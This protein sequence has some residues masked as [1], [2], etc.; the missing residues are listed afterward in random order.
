MWL[1]RQLVGMFKYLEPLWLGSKDKVSIRRVL[2]LCFSWDFI[3]NLSFAIRKWE[4]GRS[5]ADVAMVLGI[6][7]GLIAALLTLTTYSASLNKPPS[8]ASE[9]EGSD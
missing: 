5:Y 9:A 2:A 4:I 8:P 6:E 7:A 1:G 3:H